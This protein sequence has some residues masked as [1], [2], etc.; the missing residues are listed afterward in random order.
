MLLTLRKEGERMIYQGILLYQN[1]EHSMLIDIYPKL[2][3]MHSKIV[4]HKASFD[5]FSQYMENPDFFPHILLIEV[6]ENDRDAVWFPLLKN[7]ISYTPYCRIIFILEGGMDYCSL[8]LNQIPFTYILS[9]RSINILGTG[10]IKAV[11]ELNMLSTHHLSPIL[12]PLPYH[13]VVFFSTDGV[14][15]RGKK[16]CMIHYPNLRTEY[17]RDSLKNILPKLPGNFI[18]IHKSYVVN[19]NYCEKIIHKKR[20]AGNLQDNY[21]LLHEKANVTS[22]E[23]PIG[24][25]FQQNVDKY[26]INQHA[27]PISF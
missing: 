18:Q 27:Y 8:F 7:V 24:P 9:L 20:P 10:L 17:T 3:K 4:F 16:G 11:N 1:K 15:H 6:L 2:Q 19:M 23:L 5:E 12:N 22:I 14:L 26:M 21:I 25:K 13:S